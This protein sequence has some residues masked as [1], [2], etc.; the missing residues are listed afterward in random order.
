[1][2]TSNGKPHPR[3]SL[4]TTGIARSQLK[5]IVAVAGQTDSE[6]SVAAALRV[7]RDRLESDPGEFGEPLYHVASLR[8]SIRCA[9]V[10]PL[11][12]EYGLH[13]EKPVVVIRR[14]LAM[15]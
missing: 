7:I 6:D 12:V 13:D 9:A 11:Y 5:A 15:G 3:Y 8:M 4:G 1:M 14:Y 10:A 2:A